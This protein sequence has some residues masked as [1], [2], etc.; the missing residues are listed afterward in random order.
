MSS[1]ETISGHLLTRAEMN[2]QD[3]R[4]IAVSRSVDHLAEAL[5]LKGNPVHYRDGFIG[6]PRAG[7]VNMTAHALTC[8]PTAIEGAVKAP[9]R[10]ETEERGED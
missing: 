7:R 5:G 4:A 6:R 2:H 9:V 1:L 3:Y 8:E 10:S